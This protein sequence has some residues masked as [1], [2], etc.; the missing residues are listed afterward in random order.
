[1]DF[2]I[3][4][5][6]RCPCDPMRRKLWTNAIMRDVGKQLQIIQH[7]RV[8]SVHFKPEDFKRS[9]LGQQSLLCKVLKSSVVL[10]IFEWSSTAEPRT[11]HLLKRHTP[12]KQNEHSA[13]QDPSPDENSWTADVPSPYADHVYAVRGNA[14]FHEDPKH[15]TLKERP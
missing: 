7:T 13:H 10:S 8:C 11:R 5:F 2:T 4:S 3:A 6:H 9:M 1:M 12:N 15:W 14:E